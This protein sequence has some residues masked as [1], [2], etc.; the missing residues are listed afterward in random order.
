MKIYFDPKARAL[1]HVVLSASICWA[2]VAL[3]AC[4]TTSKPVDVVGSFKTD[5]YLGTWYEIARYDF[6][7]ERDLSHVTATYSMNPNGTIKVDNRGYAYKRSKWKRSVGKAKFVEGPDKARLKVSFFG[8]FYGGYNV[9]RLDED[10]RY[11]LVAGDNLK[12]LWLLSREKTIPESIRSSYL[13]KA[14]ELGYDIDK[15]VW[16]VQDGEVPGGAPW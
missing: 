10:Y 16:T 12:F 9:V 4:K 6:A 8:P 15:L 3:A 7:F 2:V 13:A 5:R 1:H 14:R 11:A